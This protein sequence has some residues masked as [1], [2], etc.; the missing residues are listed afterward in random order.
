VFG[1][2]TPPPA[3]TTPPD[4]TISSGPTGTTSSTSASFDFSSTEPGSSF[5]CRLDTAAFA[6]CS[7]PK[8]YSGLSAASHT[9]EVRA[10]DAAGNVDPTPASRSWT[11]SATAPATYAETVAATV[12][13]K[14]WWR[15]G[16]TGTSAADSKGTNAGTYVGGVARV[17]GLISA[18]TD[19]A[20][21]FD[22][23]NDL[24][25]LA[26]APFGT[27]AQFSIEAW[28]RIDT[29]KTGAGQHFLVTDA[30]DDLN[31]GFSLAV[32]AANKPTLAVARTASNRVT[33]V[34]SVALSL[35]TT[36]HLV[37]TYDGTTAR[38]YVNGVERAAAPYTGGV[39]YSAS[40][41]LYLGSQ[42]KAFNR[43]VRWLDGKLDEVALY[44]RALPAATIQ[45]HYDRG[46]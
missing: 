37:A 17:A 24:V 46:K 43:G 20:H 8:A 11:V 12:G 44:D 33:A 15:L 25:D 38:I 7:S 36:Q 40:R 1:P 28:V 9:F 39:T 13:L 26:P 3:D 14:D 10:T 42:N 21:D 32:D 41:E 5:E 35:A 18:D 2:A 22:G 16:E 27:P 19:A 6:A 31:D 30:F 4:T 45:G 23:A 34:S 29:Q